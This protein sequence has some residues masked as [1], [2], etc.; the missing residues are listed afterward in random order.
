MPD[1]LSHLP[2]PTLMRAARGT[3]A[4]SI[5]AQ[6][7]EI[8]V[9]DLPK[10]GAFILFGI[11]SGNGTPAD[12]PFGLGVSRQAVSQVIDVLVQRGYVER[13]PDPGDRRRIS[14]ELTE[15]GQEVVEA[16]WRGTEA[17]DG[18]LA[19][20]LSAEQIEAMRSGLM[21]LADIKAASTKAGSA[22]RRPARHFRQ[23]SPIF[24][25]RDMA[26]AL[27]HYA[28]LGFKS[29]AYEGGAFYGFAN[30]D[31]LGIHLALE[32][33]QDPASTYLY[34]RD[35]DALFDE[36]S[37]A[38]ISGVT[39]PVEP[40]PYGLREGSHVDPDGNVIRFG[41]PLHE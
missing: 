39:H 20:R 3:Y 7:Q 32:P 10:N 6:L 41:S 30:R 13:H 9:D 23:F 16:V 37:Q 4:R 40:T 28:S 14:L 34:V 1:E 22:V 21:A 5:R 31:G 2:T 18:Q 11:H 27:S 33:G 26:A 38:G 36:W 24:P 19:T 35:A 17:I 25:V 8:G 29:F 15:R 12:L